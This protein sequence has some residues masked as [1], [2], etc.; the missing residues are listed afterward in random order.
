[1]QKETGTN[2]QTNTDILDPLQTLLKGTETKYEMKTKRV[3]INNERKQI[4]KRRGRS[5]PRIRQ[6]SSSISTAIP[7]R[8]YT[9]EL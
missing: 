5:D 1:M 6:K 2:E 9:M 3:L 4:Q 7:N 8:E